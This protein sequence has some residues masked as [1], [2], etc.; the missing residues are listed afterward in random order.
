MIMLM[1]IFV[2]NLSYA[3]GEKQ[4][5]KKV[6]QQRQAILQK[7]NS[8]RK[9]ERQEANKL[10]KNQQK[11]EKNQQALRRSQNQYKAKQANIVSLQKDL[12]S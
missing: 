7:I 3:A 11:L 1:M 6:E 8:L 10:T 12:N 4:Q 9:L 2:S 5:I